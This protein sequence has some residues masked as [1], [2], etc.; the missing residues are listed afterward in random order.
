MMRWLSTRIEDRIWDSATLNEE[1]EQVRQA[2]THR[3]NHSEAAIE[4]E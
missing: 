4:S 1:I 2:L 3:S